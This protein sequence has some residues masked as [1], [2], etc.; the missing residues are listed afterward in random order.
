MDLRGGSTVGGKRIATIDD[1]LKLESIIIDS[2][3]G[4][5]TGGSAGGDWIPGEE[6]LPTYKLEVWS[7]GGDRFRNGKINTWL[8][9]RVYRGA[10]DDTGIVLNMQEYKFVWE[11]LSGNETADLV[12]AN[13]RLSNYKQHIT[14]ED[15]PADRC[16]FRCKLV[17]TVTNTVILQS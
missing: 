7:S 15:V 13:N 16:T 6:G 8:E 2:N 5:G 11:R 4:G 17:D 14:K 10:R 3:P 12:W 9:A 1:I